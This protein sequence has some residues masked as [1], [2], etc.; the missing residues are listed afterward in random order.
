M[1]TK[2]E[3][4]ELR[5]DQSLLERVDAWR[6]TQIENLSR[7]EAMRRLIETGLGLNR[8]AGEGISEGERAILAV[9]LD[10]PAAKERIRSI[11]EEGQ[12]WALSSAVPQAFTKPKEPKI[13]K[14]VSDILGMWSK[15]ESS[16]G[17]LRHGTQNKIRSMMASE[18]MEVSFPG[19][20][21]TSEPAHAQAAWYLTTKLGQFQNFK[22]RHLATG[23]MLERYYR[24]MR[25]FRPIESKNE[26]EP[27]YYLN[28][29]ESLALIKAWLGIDMGPRSVS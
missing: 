23:P 28:D 27:F 13:S 3:R 26:G 6:E 8:S 19:F 16:Y 17:Q 10:F 1:V 25:I 18:D 20:S 11:M 29:D 7:A 14:E 2:S 15:I 9:L 4:F 24:M 5:L 12:Y 22:G 21:A